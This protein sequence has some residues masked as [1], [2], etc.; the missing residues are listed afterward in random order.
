MSEVGAATIRRA[1]AVADIA[2]VEEE[3]SLWAPEILTNGVAEVC[4][5]LKIPIV[6]HTPLGAGILTGQV[7]SVD[8][9]PS[10]YLRFFP[11]FQG[12]N[13]QKNLDLVAELQKLAASKHVS[14]AQLALSWIK[15]QS[16]KPGVPFLIPIAG[17][18]SP[19]R[20][21]EN[22]TTVELSDEDFK[23]I[24][25]ILDSFPVSGDRYPAPGMKLVEF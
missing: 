9:L 1:A 8:D 5:E 16:K 23:A 14:P 12:E 18:R 24:Q 17:A 10:Q 3:V 25:A 4:A 21:K 13:F 15:L 2:M 22:A 20:V 7:K 19:E 11:R 6:A